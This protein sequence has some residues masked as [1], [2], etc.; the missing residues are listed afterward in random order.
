MVT[1]KATTT[2]GLIT[3]TSNP[4]TLNIRNNRAFAQAKQTTELKNLLTRIEKNEKAEKAEKAGKSRKAEKEEGSTEKK[5]AKE[6]VYYRIGVA[7]DNSK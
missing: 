4:T 1:P 5:K 2:S 3:P 6:S 7:H